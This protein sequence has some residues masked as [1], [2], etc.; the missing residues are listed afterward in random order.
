[1]MSV[2]AD[3]QASVEANSLAIAE[4]Q[5]HLVE[6]EA[7]NQTLREILPLDEAVE[8]PLW[9][10]SAP[11]SGSPQDDEPADPLDQIRAQALSEIRGAKEDAEA[12]RLTHRPRGAT[13]PSL[14][15]LSC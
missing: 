1:M 4:I 15:A 14:Q 10:N 11:S 7:L 6:V 12:R 13:S 8:P 2:L 3:I 5:D 9:V